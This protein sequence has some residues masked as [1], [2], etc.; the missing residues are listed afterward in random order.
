MQTEQQAEVVFECVYSVGE[1]LALAPS[2]AAG[3]L[4]KKV[5]VEDKLEDLSPTRCEPARKRKK[6]KEKV[7]QKKNS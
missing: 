3:A 7:G 2:E 1:E 5:R 6:G 4:H